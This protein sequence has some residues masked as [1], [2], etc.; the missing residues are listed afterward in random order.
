MFFVQGRTTFGGDLMSL[1]ALGRLKPWAGGTTKACF[2]GLICGYMGT[3]PCPW[4]SR[5]AA[6]WGSPHPEIWAASGPG[7]HRTAWL[8]S[9]MEKWERQL[10]AECRSRVPD[11]QLYGESDE[12]QTRRM[13]PIWKPALQRTSWVWDEHKGDTKMLPCF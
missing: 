2:N 6:L 13:C 12:N 5:T 10:P 9:R 3:T 7:T 11:A 4:E 1:D 8:R